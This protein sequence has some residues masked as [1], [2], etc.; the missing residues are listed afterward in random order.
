MKHHT[1]SSPHKHHRHHKGCRSGT[2]A[3]WRGRTWLKLAILLIILGAVVGVPFQKETEAAAPDTGAQ[4][5]AK[6]P[7]EAPAAQSYI[8][9]LRVRKGETLSGDV[10][11]WSG[12]VVIE[13]GG[14]ID[15]SLVAYAGDVEIESGGTVN[16]DLTLWAGDADIAAAKALKK[17]VAAE[18]EG[19]GIRP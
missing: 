11:V 15:G 10:N 12:D 1:C 7:M 17:D 5:A 14:R 19:Y 4:R 16:G 2:R 3:F 8:D 18:Y 6:A 9:D 13:T